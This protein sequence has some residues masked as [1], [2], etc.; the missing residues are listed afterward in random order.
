MKQFI[1]CSIFDYIELF[2]GIGN[3]KEKVTNVIKR[4]KGKEQNVKIQLS[5]SSMYSGQ[6]ELHSVLVL[7][8]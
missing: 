1:S 3:I 6:C 2:C 8:H 5:L 7:F 4:F